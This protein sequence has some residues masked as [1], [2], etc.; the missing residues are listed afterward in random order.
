[1]RGDCGERQSGGHTQG[2]GLCIDSGA[3]GCK[4]LVGW[5]RTAPKLVSVPV[6]NILKM[7]D[8]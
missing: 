6:S 3:S 5:R 4:F 8:F 2:L 1:M 7:L